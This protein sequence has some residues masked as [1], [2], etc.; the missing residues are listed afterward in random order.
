MKAIKKL[1]A[2][3]LLIACAI[4]F[5]SCTFLDFLFYTPTPEELPKRSL[6]DFSTNISSKGLSSNMIPEGFIDRFA[7]S[8]GYFY[9]YFSGDLD[10]D[11]REILFVFF[12]YDDAT[13]QLAKEYVIEQMPLSDNVVETY[14]NYCFY[15]VLGDDRYLIRYP[16]C[17]VR[18]CYN[19]TNNTLI[20]LA[21]DAYGEYRETTNEL[22]DNWGAFLDEFYGQWYDF[23][24]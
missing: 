15:D 8:E 11:S 18:F 10:P 2:V 17:F 14:N 16:D 7:Y 19:D 5:C 23:S 6:D 12:Q 3:L 20:F 22:A 1:M 4:S 13:Y 24:Q 21:L 9:Y